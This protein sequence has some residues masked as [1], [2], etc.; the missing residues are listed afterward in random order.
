MTSSRHVSFGVAIG[1]TVAALASCGSD[2]ED[3]RA[4]IEAEGTGNPYT[5]AIIESTSHDEILLPGGDMVVAADCS[6]DD[7]DLPLVTAV[8]NGLPD[9]VY[10]GVFEPAT[11]VDITLEVTGA[12]QVVATAS[13]ALDDEAYVVTFDSIEGGS[14]DLRGC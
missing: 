13:V 14:F 2:G 10:V 1:I 6:P 8:A 5:Q 11:G 4:E 12:E 7:E 9:G 3:E